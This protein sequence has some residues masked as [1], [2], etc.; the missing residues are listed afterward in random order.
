MTTTLW[1]IMFLSGVVG[2]PI[3]CWVSKKICSNEQRLLGSKSEPTE[4]VK[5]LNQLQSDALEKRNRDIEAMIEAGKKVILEKI[6][7]I[8]IPALYSAAE[9]PHHSRT[10]SFPEGNLLC[11]Y[12]DC[13]V[14]KAL[15]EFLISSL[16]ERGLQAKKGYSNYGDYNFDVSW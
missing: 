3:C 6:E 14:D 11:S 4:L 15:G 9:Q 12:N 7:S 1:I 16:K 13:P 5:K 10:L 2:V 8:V